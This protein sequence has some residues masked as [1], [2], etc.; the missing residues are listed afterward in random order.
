MRR[1]LSA[2]LQME[3]MPVG[4]S[5]AERLAGLPAELRG[6]PRPLVFDGTVNAISVPL[7]SR[8][9]EQNDNV[10]RLTLP[11]RA[12]QHNMTPGTVINMD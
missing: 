5:N 2:F 11:V 8:R 10:M 7:R 9:Y 3:G 1:L 12:P 6:G 4:L